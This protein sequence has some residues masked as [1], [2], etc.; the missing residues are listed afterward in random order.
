MESP[1]FCLIKTI[2]NSHNQTTEDI[3]NRVIEN[4]GETLNVDRCFLC[5]RDP[6]KERCRTP[7]VWRRS[8]SIA[9]DA[10][11]GKW[12][13]ESSFVDNDPLYRAALACQPSIYIADIEKASPE[14]LN[15][16]FEDRYFGHRAFIHGHIIQ[17]GRLWGTLE[18]CVFD[19]PRQWTETEQTFIE[20][21]L[22]L[23]A[24]HVK[25]F[26][27]NEQMI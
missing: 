9:G 26:V 8:D 2:L 1:E 7:F 22:P 11:H 24:D 20:T 10:F 16:E 13:D 21:L 27:T 14:I 4:I 25:K 6:S 15:R 17:D 23:L 5:V 19:H 18:P 12:V 3:L